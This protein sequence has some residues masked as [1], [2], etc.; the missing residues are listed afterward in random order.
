MSDMHI[1]E[2]LFKEALELLDR[3]IYEKME[4]EGD[5][6]YRSWLLK[7]LVDDVEEFLK[8]HKGDE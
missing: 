5:K 3:V 7:D 8:E 2:S 6:I 1:N 4:D